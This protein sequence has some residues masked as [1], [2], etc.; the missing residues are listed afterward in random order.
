[1]R[2][3]HYK[4]HDGWLADVVPFYWD[5]MFRL[6]YLHDYRDMERHGEGCPW[7]Q[8]VSKD[9]VHFEEKGD[10][11]LR[12]TKDEQ[13][14]FIYTGCVIHAQG[15]FH[16]F[17][18]GHNYHFIPDGKPQEAIMHAVSDDLEHWEKCPGEYFFAPDNYEMHDWRD[19]FI[20]FDEADGLYHMI[21]A[22]RKKSGPA[23]KRGCT[24]HATSADLREWKVQE[25][26]WDPEMYFTHECP[27]LF[28]MGDWYYLIYSEFSDEFRTRYVR[29]RSLYGPWEAPKDDVF[30]S[31]A[32]YAAKTACDGEKRYLF[33]WNPTRESNHDNGPFQ[34][35]GHLIVHEVWQD[36]AGEL[37]VRM[38]QSYKDAFAKSV[39]AD[40]EAAVSAG[41]A[42][43]EWLLENAA[44]Y[45]EIRTDKELP[46]VC[47]I[48]ADIDVAEDT[49]QVGIRFRFD[50]ERDLSY[51]MSYQPH[52]GMWSCI[53]MPRT[54]WGKLDEY[55]LQRVS[56]KN[57]DGK[58]H[59]ALLLDHDVVTLYVNDQIAL[60]TRTCNGIANH[61]A[62]YACHG[63]AKVRNIR[64]MQIE[65]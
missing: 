64:M 37:R 24:V 52:K 40:F 23:Q 36:E 60:N 25:P 42:N 9:L 45:A 50:P 31:R 35:G 63:A 47:M 20:F 34:W 19:P 56:P 10:M 26:L 65:E 11:I 62:F 39:L 38:P 17:Y 1:M 59:V 61:M 44:G 48:E 54:A 57:A 51:A 27:D 4:P 43:G 5:G 49:Q 55:S 3:F 30:D 6:F 32:F 18:T 28:K 21:L 12:G 2:R 15:K 53:S 29:S 8:I 7:R 33:G 13:D 41:Y 46:S 58:F 22:A 14:L 16:I